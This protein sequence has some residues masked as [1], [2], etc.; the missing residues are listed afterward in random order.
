[1]LADANREI[2]LAFQAADAARRTRRQF[3]VPM[4]YLDDLIWRLE[5]LQLRG[6]TELPVGIQTRLDR[7]TELLLPGIRGR[8]AW[9]R[10]TAHA[11][12]QCFALQERVLLAKEVARS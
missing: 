4:A 7:A 8:S 5:E 2:R 6:V 11:L 9:R 3:D 10:C 1:M 12:D